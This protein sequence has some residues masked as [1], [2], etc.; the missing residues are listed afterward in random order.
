[1]G[2]D[3][4]EAK[5]IAD[6]TAGNIIE[7][8]VALSA[9]RLW[10][11]QRGFYV[12]EG[13]S[14]WGEGHVPH[15]ITSN[16]VIAHAYA[17]V[18]VGFLRDCDAAGRLDH[19][20]RV[21]IL[22][23]GS[24][25]GRFAHALLRRL[26]EVLEATSLRDLPVT[27]VLS[28]FDATKLEQLAA[29][30]RFQADLAD[31]WLD[32]AT[33]DA[34][35]PG[36]VRTWRSG[37]VLADAPLV[38]IAN[39]VF[40]SLPADAYAIRQGAVHDVRLSVLADAPDVDFD[41]PGAIERLRF[42]WDVVGEAAPTT[43]D[44]DSVLARYAEVL[45]QTV[46]VM[47]TAAIACVD[48][49]AAAAR[50]PMLTLVGDK[51]WAHLRDLTGLDWPSIVPHSGCFSLMVDFDAIARV[52]RSRGGVALLP[53]HK[54]QH[55]VIGAFVLGGIDAPETSLRYDDLLAEGGPD[56]V[57]EVRGAM[58][59]SGG[60][61]T[62]EQALSVLRTWR[63]DS[64]VF[65]DLFP[66]LL[67]VAPQLTGPAKADLGLAVRRV[68]DAWF[69]IGEAADI[70]LCLGLLLS[71]I[72]H[73]REALEMFGRSHEVVGR[74]ANACLASAVAHHELRELEDALKDVTEALSMEPTLD[75]ARALA[76]D[77]ELALGRDDGGVTPG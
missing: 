75:A 49:L 30:P 21:H 36:E 38:L 43:P 24:G 56:D 69:W 46:V 45:D 34:S 8:S 23:L 13:L 35:A 14:A 18:I 39:Y 26:R 42:A 54:A 37:A 63:W 77:I 61:L 7:H 73:H 11:L 68:W 65:L 33:V 67:Q 76:V 25:S 10:E 52:V 41:T 57:F 72:G 29:H 2:L 51:G 22:E 9:S 12:R 17:E 59:P 1:V 40:D 70:A 48:G 16:P 64:Q 5:Q 15:Q 58:A 60:Q 53:P 74:N 47:P 6:L 55:L 4:T 19:S 50:A 20:R 31:G 28:D 27:L 66:V 3:V 32:L 71:G 62:L 44:I